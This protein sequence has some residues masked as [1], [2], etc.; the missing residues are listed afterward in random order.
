MSPKSRHQI[1]YV[2]NRLS[3]G[4]VGKLTRVTAVVESES[5]KKDFPRKEQT[6]PFRVID[7]FIDFLLPSISSKTS[8]AIT[9]LANFAPVRS[10]RILLIHET[11]SQILVCCSNSW[12]EI[13]CQVMGIMSTV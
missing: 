8:G 2:A 11:V 13:V 10:S 4:N 7:G 9:G 5:F 12:L 3:C 1:Y 6:A